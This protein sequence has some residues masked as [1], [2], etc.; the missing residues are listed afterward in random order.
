MS[1]GSISVGVV[2][3]WGSYT[4]GV[5]GYTSGGGGGSIPAEV[6]YQWGPYTSG[7][8]IPVGDVYQ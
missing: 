3:Q 7:G 8:C 4:S 2:Y 6:I 5:G 1:V